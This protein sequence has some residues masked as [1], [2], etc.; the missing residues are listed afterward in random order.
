MAFVPFVRF[1]PGALT[2]DE[3]RYMPSAG[4]ERETRIDAMVTRA[5][6]R[7]EDRRKGWL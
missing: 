6:P 2:W 5:L 1:G 4:M 7:S 3:T